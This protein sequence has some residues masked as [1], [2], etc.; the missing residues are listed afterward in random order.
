MGI[1]FFSLYRLKSFEER[2]KNELNVFDRNSHL[3]LYK[4]NE[5]LKGKHFRKL[6]VRTKIRM[7]ENLK[8][9]AEDISTISESSSNDSTSSSS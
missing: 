8:L 4:I 5:H 1:Q 7:E 9:S 6:V 2:N 3:I